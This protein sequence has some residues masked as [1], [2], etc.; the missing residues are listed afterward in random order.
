MDLPPQH[1]TPAAHAQFT[2]SCCDHK[3]LKTPI[4]ANQRPLSDKPG[5]PHPNQA[6]STTVKAAQQQKTPAQDRS[7]PLM[8]QHPYTLQLL[9]VSKTFAQQC[10]YI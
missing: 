4:N 5:L 7:K 2:L 10:V 9:N 8:L 1:L 6:A 3:L